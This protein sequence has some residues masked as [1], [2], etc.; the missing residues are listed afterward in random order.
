MSAL[1]Q[2]AFLV[3]TVIVAVVVAVVGLDYTL[4]VGSKQT[5]IQKIVEFVESPEFCWDSTLSLV[6]RHEQVVGIHFG[7]RFFGQANFGFK[8]RIDKQ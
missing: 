4:A 3:V 5:K 2:V 7:S 8:S 1:A 6:L